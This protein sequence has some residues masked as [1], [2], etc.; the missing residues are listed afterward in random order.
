[1]KNFLV[2]MLFLGMTLF[3]GAALANN[4]AV[5]SVSITSQSTANQTANVQFNITWNNSW[6][7]SVNYD[8]AWVFVKY[9]TDA[10]VTWAHATLAATGGTAT[11]SGNGIIN[12]TGYSV[13]SGTALQIIVPTEASSG[14]K[15]AFLQRSANGAGTVT[16]TGVQVVWNWSGDKLSSD[17]VTAI[18]ASTTVRVKVFAIE[19]VYVPTG[20]FY[21]GDGTSTSVTGQFCTGT[22]TSSPFLVSSQAAMTLGGGGANLGNNGASGMSPADDWN[23]ST[24]KSLLSTFPEGYNAFYMMKYDVTQGQWRDFLNLLTRAQQNGRVYDAP[25]NDG[26][27]LTGATSLPTNVYVMS[28]SSGLSYRNGIKVITIPSSSA[29]MTFGCYLNAQSSGI[30][31]GTDD[32]EWVAMNYLSWTDGA[33]YA[34]WAGLRPF[35]EFEYEK[36][37]RGPSS[38]DTGTNG[39]YAWG[40]TTLTNA[41]GFSGT[42]AGTSSETT[43]PSGA[44]CLITGGI[45]GPV[46]GGTFA[47]SSSSRAT[48]GAGYW[49]I[50]DLSGNLWKRPVTV[51]KSTG[52]AFVGSNGSGVLASDGNATNCDWPGSSTTCPT[53]GE[54]NSSGTYGT[55]G[56]R[57]GDWYDASTHA[58]V[59][60]RSYAAVVYTNRNIHVGARFARTSP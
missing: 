40:N 52:R 36:A 4:I 20:S 43:T 44:N 29:A 34:A 53:V 22:T 37:A 57:G 59:S 27:N 35:T 25:A 58:R 50:M 45:S 33:A 10:G 47:T 39:E 14:Y 28:N 42:T 16:T 2:M 56:F 8:A 23:N 13:G 24:T 26:P 11:S 7:N 19:M 21:L 38:V 12:P 9:S 46:R 54:V 6:R 17:G 48:A 51:G 55:C 1:M 31:N 18:T 41:T 30:V 15:G 5:S 3:A 49:G 32:G 60:D